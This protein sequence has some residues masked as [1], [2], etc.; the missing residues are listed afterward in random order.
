MFTP[1]PYLRLLL[2]KGILL[3]G[4]VAY[5]QEAGVSG[6][7][8]GG[9]SGRAESAAIRGSSAPTAGLAAAATQEV[10]IPKGASVTLRAGSQGASSY[11]WFKD[12]EAISG[13]SQA[14]YAAGEDGVYTVLAYNAEGCSSDMSE[15]VQVIVE[16]S[17]IAADLRI[18]KKSEDRQVVVNQTFDYWLTVS[19]NGAGEASSVFV[20]DILPQ[21]LEFEQLDLPDLGAADYETATHTVIWKIDALEE[22]ATASLKIRVKALQA[23]WIENTA[24]V[25]GSQDD[26]DPSN[27]I[28]IDRKNVAGLWVPNVVTP[29]GDGKNDRLQIPGLGNFVENE[30][31]ILNRWGN[32]VFEQKGYQHNWTGEG[33]NEGTYYY[34][35]KVKTAGGSWQAFKGYITLL[36]GRVNAD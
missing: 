3:F 26:P 17:T 10:R 24:T 2:L 15:G 1:T 9:S 30:L 32:H 5:A 6:G 33:L 35:L 7:G 36:R 16:E 18:L 25:G 20:T 12:G 14:E 31:V 19:N 13:A 23:G 11:M 4:R 8:N 34:L 29:N 27:N 22:G 28:S 21:E